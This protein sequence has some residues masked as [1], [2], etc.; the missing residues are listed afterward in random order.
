MKFDQ[1]KKKNRRRCPEHR[2]N[3]LVSRDTNRTF[4]LFQT[5]RP[6][7]TRVIGMQ[8]VQLTD[9]TDDRGSRAKDNS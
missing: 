9:E 7:S 3:T 5:E 6:Q 1:A 2:N 4:V 8:E